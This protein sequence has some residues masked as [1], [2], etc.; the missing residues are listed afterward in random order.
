MPGDSTKVSGKK[1][2]LRES[3]SGRERKRWE[4][5]HPRKRNLREKVEREPYSTIK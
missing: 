4:A 5:W 1:W 3:E 2:K